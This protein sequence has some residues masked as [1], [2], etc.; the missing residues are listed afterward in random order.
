MTGRFAIGSVWLGALLAPCAIGGCAATAQDARL[1]VGEDTA[2]DADAGIRVPDGFDAEVFAAGVG[3]ARH[4]VVRDNGDLYVALRQPNQGGGVAALRDEN[5]DGAADRIEYFGDHVGTGIAIQGG[6]LYVSSDRAIFRYALPDGAGLVPEGPAEPVVEGF[7]EQRSHASK[8]FKIDGAGHLYVNVGAPSNACQEDDRTAGSPGQEPCPLLA[9]HAGIWRF[10][11]DKTGQS[12]ADGERF[13]TGT[14]NIVALDWDPAAD[15]VWFAMHGRDQLH[16]L[17]PDLY[18]EQQSAELPAEELHRARAGADY[19]WPYTYWD[20][21]RGERMAGPEYGGDGRT[22]VDGD[23]Q[24]PAL[25]FPGHWAPND[26]L[27]YTAADAFPAAAGGGLFIAFHGSWN[28]APL[29]QGGYCVV[30]VP[31][32]DGAPTGRWSVF[33]DGFKGAGTL[34]DPDDAAY[35]PMGLAQAPDGALYIAEFGR[36]AD[37]AGNLRRLSAAAGAAAPGSLLEREAALDRSLVGVPGAHQ[38]LVFELFALRDELGWDGDLVGGQTARQVDAVDEQGRLL[39]LDHEL[40]ALDPDRRIGRAADRGMGGGD[41]VPADH[42]RR[43]DGRRLRVAVFGERHARD[44]DVA[45]RGRHAVAE[46]GAAFELVAREV[47]PEIA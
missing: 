30:F 8:A 13:V 38:D 16:Q 19:G 24:A 14:R 18:T 42:D 47:R 17:Y 40:V 41:R 27:V 34:A 43:G 2:V 28:R 36:G 11:A 37:L 1:A 10:D 7:P 35:R 39:A 46:L 3:R 29:P 12:F 45:R 44:Q 26:L 5:G 20:Q 23:D 21:M 31:F 4:L 15:Q 25:A 32:A 33:A 9:E 6:F 22:P